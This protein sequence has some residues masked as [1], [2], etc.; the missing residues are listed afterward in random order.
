M[1]TLN[2]TKSKDFTQKLLSESTLLYLEDEDVIREETSKL[3]EK[4]FKTVH[5]APNGER[6]LELYNTHKNQI[7][8]ILTDINMPIMDGLNFM[9]KIREVDLDIPILI[10]TAFNDTNQLV[11]AIKYKVSDYIVKP[12][13]LNTTLKIMDKILQDRLN[14]KTISKQK[15][16]LDIYK[17]IINEENLISET[18]LEGKIT[19]VNDSFIETSGFSK[20]ELIGKKHNI[21]KH[22][23]VSPMLYEELWKTITSKKTWRGKIKNLAK[24]GTTYYMKCTIFPILDTDENI[25]KFVS[26]RFLITDQEEEKH[27]LKKYILNQKTAQMKH[28]KELQVQF[29]E[30]LHYAKMQKDE[31]VAKFVNSQNEQIKSLKTKHSDDK[32][33][34]ISLENKLKASLDKYDEMTSI[35]QVKFKELHQTTKASIDEYQK[36]KKKYEIISTKFEKSQD[37]IKTLQDY[38]DEYRKK[39]EDLK[40]VIAAYEK[41]FGQLAVK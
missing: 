23:D 11:Q 32:G 30:A 18:D 13:Q 28:E 10:I 4:V 27:K 3:F 20:E 2:Q 8:I 26:S 5:V 19:Y 7:N 29:D 37:A 38:I 35:Y 6:G 14:L 9:K 31:Q 15:H 22:P 1:D 17:D 39:I 41:Q 25:E 34:I 40:D 33:R 21:M 16:E 36:I 24:D 12:I